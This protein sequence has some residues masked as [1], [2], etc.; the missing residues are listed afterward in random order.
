MV[1]QLCGHADIVKIL[2]SAG[3]DV[4]IYNK[5][6]NYSALAFAVQFDNQELT[7]M[8]I[9][10]GAEVEVPAEKELIGTGT[11]ANNKTLI[12][13]LISAV[14][15]GHA[16]LVEELLKSGTDV[17]A[18]D[19]DGDTALMTAIKIRSKPIFQLLIS[20][21]AEVNTENDK[22]ETALYLAVTQG[23]AEYKRMQLEEDKNQQNHVLN[24]ELSLKASS[25][26]VYTL[27]RVGAHLHET[28]SGLNPC[29]VHLTSI[30]FKNPN[31]TVLKLDAAGSQI[32][33]RE[34]STVIPLQ[35][36]VQDF[37][38]EHLKQ[39]YP[40]RNLYFT[41]PQL[42]LPQLLKSSL[43]FHTLQKYDLI[44]NSE[45]KKLLLKIKE[46]DTKSTQLLINSGV[47]VNVQ[48]E[49]GMTG[50]MIAYQTGHKE[51]VEQLIKSGAD[52]NLQDSSGHTALMKTALKH[53]RDNDS[54]TDSLKYGTLIKIQECMQVLL[55]H[56]PNLNIQDKDGN[57]ALIHVAEDMLY[58]RKTCKPLNYAKEVE[59]TLAALEQCA[60]A[61]IDAGT[62]PNLKNVKGCTALM[63]GYSNLNFVQKVI[64][65]GA[66]VNWKDKDGNTA[67]NLAADLGEVECVE[68]LIES[69]AEINSGDET[70]LMTAAEN[71]HVD[72]VKLLIRAG[73]DLDIEGKNGT[74]LWWAAFQGHVECVNLLIQA[75]ADLDTQN[76]KGL[77]ALI[78]AVGNECIECVKLL[79]QEGADLD[80]Q[81]KNG[82]TALMAATVEG[83]VECV[84]LL[85]GAGANLNI[86]NQDGYT[87]LMLAAD[88]RYVECVKLLIRE[89]A[90]LDTQGKHGRTALMAATVEGHVE[91]VKLLARAGADFNIRGKD[92]HTAVMIAACSGANSCFITLLQAGA[93][94]NSSDL[95]RMLCGKHQSNPKDA[96]GKILNL[97]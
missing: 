91:C 68:K 89:G 3:A 24:E 6:Q 67:L 25:F 54:V 38:R 84:K 23:H 15:K 27:L 26:M 95:R 11:S 30:E 9:A 64:Q 33:A 16:K 80:I 63:F 32:K 21:G 40:K 77:T 2:L 83:H 48:D 66:D 86:Q 82:R 39:V 61:L 31:P 62:D 69:G 55:Q 20:H 79:I 70:P 44:P 76:E 85:A 58:W 49:N 57:T 72:C 87:A 12:E 18:T 29:I 41:V 97:V 71:G 92:G 81:S 45:E 5:N 37:I 43:L 1:E 10:A 65:V 36:Y 34:L 90:D 88:Q 4:N 75:G 42:D 50:F 7:K 51:L 35:D 94:V 28:T 14:R 73:A 74:A 47:D 19:E 13:P 53:S 17:N 96:P 59:E 52:V 60:F 93:E 56:N 78:W 22:G 8:L 46:G